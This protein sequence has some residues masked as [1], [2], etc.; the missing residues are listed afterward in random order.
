MD[1][2]PRAVDVIE[3]GTGPWLAGVASPAGRAGWV[4]V[5]LAARRRARGVL[6]ATG[7]PSGTAQG[8]RA[9]DG[10]GRGELLDLTARGA[11]ALLRGSRNEGPRPVTVTSLIGRDGGLRLHMRDDEEPTSARARRSR[12]RCPCDSPV[13]TPRGWRG[14]PARRAG[15]PSSRRRCDQQGRRARAGSPRPRRGRH[16]VRRPPRTR[17]TTSFSGRVRPRGHGEGRRG[18]LRRPHGGRRVTAG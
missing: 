11:G 3:N 2:R 17:A 15:D 10:A 12:S 6:S 9:D 4:A 13:P 1:G 18:R 16:P 14:P 7:P 8:G 5:V